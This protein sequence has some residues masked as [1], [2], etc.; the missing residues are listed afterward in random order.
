MSEFESQNKKVLKRLK[1]GYTI[2][3][4]QA[5]HWYDCDR[6]ASRIRDLRELGHVIETIMVKKNNKRFGKYRLVS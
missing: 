5:S 6:L 2:T 1:K 3:P 4:R